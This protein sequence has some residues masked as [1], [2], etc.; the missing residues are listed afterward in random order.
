V[1]LGAISL[2]MFGV[3]LGGSVYLLPIFARDIIGPGGAGRSPEETLGYLRAAPAAGALVMALILTHTPPLR[4]A[5]RTMLLAVAGF[6][7]ATIVFGLSRNFWLSMAMLALTGSLDNI[8]VV[9]RHTMVQLATPNEMR[10]RVS[11]VNAMFISS[12]N[13]LGGFESGTVAHY[14]GP[15]VSVVSGGIGTVA[16]VLAWAGLFPGLRKVGRLAE[17]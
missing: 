4:R 15:I 5:G 1:L 11:A 14:F 12:S 17:H 2:D 13:E 8:S 9:V 10:G 16:I 7:A 6:G 3:L